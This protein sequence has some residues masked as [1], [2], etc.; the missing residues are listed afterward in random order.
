[1]AWRKRPSEVRWDN[2]CNERANDGHLVDVEAT[3]RATRSGASIEVAA[4]EIMFRATYQDLF[5]FVSRRVAPGNAA[6]VVAETYIVAW[7][8]R[9]DVVAGRERVWLFG[10]ASK[11]AANDRRAEARR[12]RLVIRLGADLALSPPEAHDP[13]EDMSRDEVLSA[14]L[15]TLSAGEREV[16]R[17]IEWDGLSRRDAAHVVGCSEATFRVRLHRARRRLANELVPRSQG[18]KQN[19]R[20]S[21]SAE[22]SIARG[23][24]ERPN[25]ENIP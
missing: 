9:A 6:D 17:L 14:A 2:G 19:D 13:T 16:L 3:E 22:A 5:R 24:S 11:L 1:M 15:S 18:T 20:K 21:M 25:D 8:R 7:R 10:I 12:D 23:P 4:F